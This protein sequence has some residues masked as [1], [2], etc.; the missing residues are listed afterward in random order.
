MAAMRLAIRI[1]AQV[2]AAPRENA[3]S[4]KKWRQFLSDDSGATMVEYA[5]TVV[6]IAAISVVIVSTIGG[7][8][9]GLLNVSGAF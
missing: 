4:A 3:M 7:I 8:T 9:E 6:L 5:I 1:P 2:G